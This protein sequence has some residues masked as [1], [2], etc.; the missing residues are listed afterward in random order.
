MSVVNYAQ[1]FKKKAKIGL[2]GLNPHNDE[3]RTNS[4]ERKILIPLVKKLKKRGLKIQGPLSVDNV[5]LKKKI[6]YDVVVGMYHDQVLGPFK[7]INKFNG[8]NV[9][10]GLKYLRISPDHG[11]NEI[12]LGKNKSNP[13]SLIKAI[14]FLDKNWLKQKKV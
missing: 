5:F 2:L 9:T 14:T 11:P 1:K 12:M 13:L 4:F 3:M 6:E 7:A 8:I 10:L